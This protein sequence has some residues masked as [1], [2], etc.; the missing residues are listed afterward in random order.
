MTLSTTTSRI[1]YNGSGSTGPFAYTFRVLAATDLVLTKRDADDVESTLT[2]PADYSVSGVGNRSGGSVTLT[3][4]LE[5]GEV[6]VIRRVRPFTQ[7]TDIKNA[8]AYFPEEHEQALDHFIMVSQQLQEQLN[9]CLKTAVTAGPT[10]DLELPIPEAGKGL[11]W[12]ADGSTLENRTLT[13]AVIALP[14]GGRTVASL[15][16]YVDNNAIWNVKDFG[17]TDTTGASDMTTYIQAALTAAGA[18][19]GGEVY[20]PAGTYRVD[21]VLS[22]PSKVRVRGAGMSVTTVKHGGAS[23]VNVFQNTTF[24][25]GGNTDIEIC[26]M[27]IDGNKAGGSGLHCVRF[28]GV[29]RGRLVRCR[30]INGVWANI[31]VKSDASLA[32][33]INQDIQILDCDISYS[34]DS[35]IDL[36]DAVRWI[37]AGCT[38][39]DNDQTGLNIEPNVAQEHVKQGIAV[40]NVITAPNIAV[41]GGMGIHVMGYSQGT[42]EGVIED[43]TIT[44]NTLSQLRFAI[45][46][47]GANVRGVTITGNLAAN[48]RHYGIAVAT[49]ATAT[50]DVQITGN[51]V[52]NPST[53]SLGTYSG[54]WLQNARRCVVVGNALVDTNGSPNMKHGVLEASASTLNMIA[55]NRVSGLTD[56]AVVSLGTGTERTGLGTF[57]NQGFIRVRPPATADARYRMDVQMTSSGEGHIVAYDDDTSTYKPLILQ[58]GTLQLT[59]TALGAF[60][61]SGTTK[62]TVTGSRGANAALASLLTALAAYGLITDGSSA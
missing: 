11:V 59:D 1:Q 17:A 34:D 56:L 4:A 28:T 13:D 31:I 6:L 2:Y 9:R 40:N 20:F 7:E 36:A 48:I 24:A 38:M 5:T 25:V 26:D 32:A 27:T 8:G 21:S 41:P 23:N 44:G 3:V 46:V 43:V 12:S 18:A 16:Q 49:G 35:A 50:K 60:G 54:I 45:Q 39:T 14:G 19:G 22:I 33:G 52:V 53:A 30:I 62:Q 47:E 10:T 51:I 29:V 55:D 57:V 37:V 58:S 15:T 42:Y 61:G